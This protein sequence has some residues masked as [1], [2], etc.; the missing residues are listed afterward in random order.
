M[1]DYTSLI[2]GFFLFRIDLPAFFPDEDIILR[3]LSFTSIPFDYS[4]NPGNATIH[5][6]SDLCD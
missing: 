5:P 6:L 4:C 3:M 1:T 2:Y